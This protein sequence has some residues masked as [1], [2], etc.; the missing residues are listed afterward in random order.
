MV[1]IALEGQHRWDSVQPYTREQW[2]A[3]HAWLD[4]VAQFAKNMDMDAESLAKADARVRFE[5][6][7][8]G[9]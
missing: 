2:H 7:H 1:L 8:F 5:L 3:I 4:H 9:L 6:E